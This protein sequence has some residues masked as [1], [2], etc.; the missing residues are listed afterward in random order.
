M[1]EEPACT[2]EKMH[3]STRCI[4]LSGYNVNE[5]S[6]VKT[7]EENMISNEVTCSTNDDIHVATPIVSPPI[8]FI[9]LSI[10]ASTPLLPMNISLSPPLINVLCSPPPPPLS[11]AHSERA[12]TK[13][14]KYY[15]LVKKAKKYDKIKY[16]ANGR[17]CAFTNE[18]SKRMIILAISF[19]LLINPLVASAHLFFLICHAILNEL[20]VDVKY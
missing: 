16:F 12:R 18:M 6:H 4:L 10:V 1:K 11:S 13:R 17:I 15:E 14:K 3:P 9:R 8:L 7:I 19:P 5:E 20:G 2:Q